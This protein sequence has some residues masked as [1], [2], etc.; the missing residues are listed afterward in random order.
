VGEGVAVWGEGGGSG[1]GREVA[2]WGEGG[3]TVRVKR[4]IGPEPLL[5]LPWGELGRVGSYEK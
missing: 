1:G 2:V 3:G 5:R 4:G